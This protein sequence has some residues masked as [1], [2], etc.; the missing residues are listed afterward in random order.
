MIYL[1]A[2]HIDTEY[3][4]CVSSLPSGSK[5]ASIFTRIP[6]LM[7]LIPESR[8]LLGVSHPTEEPFMLNWKFTLLANEF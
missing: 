7:S 4:T 6:P 3:L 2:S 5:S 8:E 1:A